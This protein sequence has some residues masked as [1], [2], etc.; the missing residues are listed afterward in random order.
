MTTIGLIGNGIVGESVHHSF[1]GMDFRIY[2]T[3]SSKSMNTILE[4]V[5]ESDFIYICVPTPMKSD[6]SFDSNILASVIDSITKYTD[7]TD[8]LIII[9]STTVPGTTQEYIDSYPNSH[10]INC[11]EFLREAHYLEDAEDPSRIVF[12]IDGD[13]D[14]FYF[15]HD[16]LF[17]LYKDV[18]KD[19]PTFFTNPTTAEM[20]KYTSNCFLATKVSFFNEIFTI[21]RKLDID[22]DDMIPMVMADKR[23]GNSH[24]KV[25][26]SD[27][28]RGFS[29]LCFPKD[30][31]ALIKK[32]IE[33]G[34]SPTMLLATWEKN[35]EVRPEKD[36]EE[37]K[38]AT[39]D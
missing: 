25:P 37:I 15:I 27:G 29:G 28:K 33:L 18:F 26:G 11:P 9:K 23:I 38:G 24:Y 1:K 39:S 32:A 10:I 3:D 7:D 21:C 12:G 6:G 35:L 31:N 2:D 36:W 16:K 14:N 22:Y 34:I 13:K 19:T 8:K 4:T 30:L 17:E 20:V 5:R